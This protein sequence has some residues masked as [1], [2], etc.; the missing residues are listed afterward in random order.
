LRASIPYI[1]RNAGLAK[2]IFK[3]ITE[4][5]IVKVSRFSGWNNRKIRLLGV[6]FKKLKTNNYIIIYFNIL[7]LVSVYDRWLVN[8]TVGCF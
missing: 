5:L 2:N 1:I 4:I 6:V 8:T 7:P 3:K